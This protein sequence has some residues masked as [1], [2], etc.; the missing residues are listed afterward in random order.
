M[1][2]RCSQQE[3]VIALGVWSSLRR[4]GS[5]GQSCQ[6]LP[7]D[8][9]GWVRFLCF[10]CAC[11]CHITARSPLCPARSHA[12]IRAVCLH[13]NERRSNTR[14]SKYAQVF[15]AVSVSSPRRLTTASNQPAGSL[16]V[17]VES[18]GPVSAITCALGPLEPSRCLGNNAAISS[19]LQACH[20]AS[21]DVLVTKNQPDRNLNG[22]SHN[23]LVK[24]GDNKVG[25][26]ACRWS[27]KLLLAPLQ[28]TLL[29]LDWLF[30]HHNHNSTHTMMAFC[31]LR[32][33][34]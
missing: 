11:S 10:M 33:M 29:V 4:I 30:T 8:S 24:K 28:I 3:R 9:P 13:M 34:V 18:S 21:R 15:A 23:G 25:S 31:S 16:T 1:L 32:R 27:Q 19:L 17:T 5:S 14:A 22:N 20:W 26:G 2:C 7:K 12:P 6:A